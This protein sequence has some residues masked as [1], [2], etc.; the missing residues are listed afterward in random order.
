MAPVIKQG[1]HWQGEV[2]AVDSLGNVLTNFV[3]AELKP[4]AK[5]STLWIEFEKTPVT[6]RGLSKTLAEGSPGK[7]LALEGAKGTLEIAVNQGNAALLTHLSVGDR[8][9]VYFRA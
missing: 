4:L 2:L 1:S 5:T 8:V 9:D 7:L 6:V 3:V